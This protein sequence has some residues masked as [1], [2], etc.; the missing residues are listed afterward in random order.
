[1]LRQSITRMRE[2]LNDAEKSSQVMLDK[3]PLER[4][5]G[6]ARVDLYWSEL[7]NE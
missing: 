6:E 1:M 5:H 7:N 4:Q 3:Y 2:I